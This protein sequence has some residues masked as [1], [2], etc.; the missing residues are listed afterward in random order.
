MSDEACVD[1]SRKKKAETSSLMP[2]N[3]AIDSTS[4]AANAAIHRRFTL[5]SPPPVKLAPPETEG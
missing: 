4:S 2:V 3:A 5:I 1:E